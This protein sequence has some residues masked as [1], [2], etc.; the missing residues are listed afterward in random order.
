[1]RFGDLV[2]DL[3]RYRVLL[4]ERPLV[5]S[6]REYALLLYLAGRAGQTV[7]KR[8][9]L[10]EGLGR[11]DPGGLRTV[12]EHLRHLKSVLERDGHAFIE[13]VGE[14]GYRFIMLQAPSHRPQARPAA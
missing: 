6:Y 13:A 12:D 4:A 2:I 9:L 5:L 8:R 3:E 14:T 10:E 1:M 7:P 11:H